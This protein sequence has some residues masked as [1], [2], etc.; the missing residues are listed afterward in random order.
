[1]TATANEKQRLSVDWHEQ[2]TAQRRSRKASSLRKSS[3]AQVSTERPSHP[4][5]LGDAVAEKPEI[6][7]E[8]SFQIPV[9]IQAVREQSCQIRKVDD[10]GRREFNHPGFSIHTCER[11]STTSPGSPNNSCQL[12][13]IHNGSWP[14]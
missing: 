8:I 11:D 2:P 1:V 7:S 13:R 14:I 9:A 4:H 5:C 12:P 10:I 3:Y 6:V